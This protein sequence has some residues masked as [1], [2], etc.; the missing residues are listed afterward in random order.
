MGASPMTPAEHAGMP[1]GGF[2]IPAFVWL[3]DQGIEVRFSSTLGEP[4]GNGADGSDR[5]LIAPGEGKSALQFANAGDAIG[6]AWQEVSDSGHGVIKLRGVAQDAGPF[7]AEIT[8]GGGANP[9]LSHHSLAISGYTFSGN[10]A[11]GAG[12]GLNLGWVASDATDAP[13]EG[14][15]MMQ[16]FALTYGDSGGPSLVPI[17]VAHGAFHTISEFAAVEAN[18]DGAANDN[19]VWVGDEDGTGGA[20]GRLPTI[21]TLDTGDTLVAWVGSEGHVH[22]KLYGTGEDNGAV[23]PEHVAINAALADLTPD[24]GREGSGPAHDIRRLKLSDLGAGNFALVWMVAA[25]ADAMLNGAVF[26]VKVDAANGAEASTDWVQTPVA[27]VPLPAGFTGDFDVTN[28]HGSEL[29]LSYTVTDGSSTVATTVVAQSIS[30]PETVL[31]KETA[32]LGPADKADLGL[33]VSK[34][35]FHGNSGSLFSAP[36]AHPSIA[37]DTHS[38]PPMAAATHTTT[39]IAAHTQ[40]LTVTANT[41]G[42]AALFT[43]LGA[44]TMGV[45]VKIFDGD[46]AATGDGSLINVT[47]SADPN[48]AP[49]VTRIGDGGVVVAWV[50]ASAGD[51]RTQTFD[52]HGDALA[53]DGGQ[54]VAS[55]HKVSDIALASNSAADAAHMDAAAYAFE[56]ALAWVLD[57]DF[58]GFG[59]IMLQRYWVPS[60]AD[61]AS[62]PSPVALG[63]D[64]HAGDNDDAEQL[65]VDSDHGPVGVMGRAPQLTGLSQGEL[66]MSWV[67]NSGE[68]ETVRG[69]VLA[70]DGGHAVLNIDLSAQLDDPAIVAKGT[71]PIISSAANGDILV[72]W[73]EPD[74]N[75]GFDVKG[76]LYKSAGDSAWTLP[77]KVLDF[78][79]F[80]TEPKDFSVGLSDGADPSILLTWES[81]DNSVGVRGQRFDLGGDHLGNSFGIRDGHVDDSSDTASLPDGQIVVVYAEQDQNGDL[82][83]ESHVVATGGD[84]GSLPAPA[85]VVS[86]GSDHI[87][88]DRGS[89]DSYAGLGDYGSLSLASPLASDKDITVAED[90]TDGVIIDV[91][92][93]SQA[94]GGLRVVQVNGADIAIGAPLRVEHG[95]VQLRDDGDLL[96]TADEH[97]NGTVNFDYTVSSLDDQLA[98]ASVAINVTPVEDD[99]MPVD[100]ALDQ[101]HDS[102]LPADTTIAALAGA[103]DNSGHGTADSTQAP[104]DTADHAA[105]GQIGQATEPVS[106]GHGGAQDT[107]AA[108]PGGAG[109]G[110][111][112][113]QAQVQDGAGQLNTGPG[114]QPQPT[115]TGDAGK[116]GQPQDT[117][118]A[119][120]GHGP[121]ATAAAG[122]STETAA[123]SAFGEAPDTIAL[124]PRYEQGNVERQWLQLDASAIGSASQDGPSGD[125]AAW[126]DNDTFV[127]HAAFGNEAAETRGLEHVIDLSSSGYPTFQALHDSGALVQVGSD[128]EITL[129]HTDPSHPEKI[130]LRSVDLSTLTAS[131]FKFG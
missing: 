24:Y 112:G 126:H 110:P 32:D 84:D 43:V 23:A 36:E 88:A 40:T 54:T 22:G 74:G 72:A 125:P 95:F 82:D 128:V 107:T 108:A 118:T 111:D 49:A 130:L 34:V 61:G 58:D 120:A 65:S 46:G 127:F 102:T 10:Q 83:I 21:A 4:N 64:G 92:D 45:R 19:S 1:A 59:R 115:A 55:G 103:N 79:H 119:D 37:V 35:A 68:Q 47:D 73:L 5:V 38:V 41:E 87:F 9:G 50:D 69:A 12:S 56:F 117:T 89:L 27:P 98:T 3:S 28:G 67:E 26:S 97:F 77:D 114:S 7:G 57:A 124:A 90:A 113:G 17:T 99:P 121:E 14:R 2:G 52:S 71:H 75:S 8:V 6:V 109:P 80:D 86:D 42:I 85:P 31:G 101:A 131:D 96:F 30:L 66:A 20:I 11:G 104:N 122:D 29:A 129:N 18:E 106:G 16:R 70:R 116:D 78:Q 39:D 33:P 15:I 100:L 25:G 63:R 123:L 81:E 94:D 91:L 53:A 13:G 48:V 51:L 105:T 44:G 93:D 60:A 62:D 76:A